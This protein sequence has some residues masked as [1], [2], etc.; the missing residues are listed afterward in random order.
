MARD[1]GRPSRSL[2][3]SLIRAT[4]RILGRIILLPCKNRL[5]WA[6]DRSIIMTRLADV[7]AAEMRAAAGFHR[8]RHHH[9]AR[10]PGKPG[11]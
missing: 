7:M 5:T 8:Y 6:G 3:S 2:V 9:R 4:N 10:Q 1:G 11:A